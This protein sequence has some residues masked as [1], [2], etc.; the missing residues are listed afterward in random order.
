[1]E[2]ILNPK[3]PTKTSKREQK[4]SEINSTSGEAEGWYIDSTHNLDERRRLI[5]DNSEWYEKHRTRRHIMKYQTEEERLNDVIQDY[6]ANMSDTE[7]IE[8][9][10][11]MVKL[12]DFLMK[13]LDNDSDFEKVLASRPPTQ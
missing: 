8:H 7:A 5:K 4:I 11:N 13:T 9:L 6:T 1:M 12:D 2:A 3:S 10:Y